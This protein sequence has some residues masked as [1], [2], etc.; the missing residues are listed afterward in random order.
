MQIS[1]MNK[2][3]LLPETQRRSLV[4][5]GTNAYVSA[6]RKIGREELLA[7]IDGKLHVDE[8]QTLRIRV[9]QTEGRLLAQIE[10][11]ARILMRV[12][13]DRAVQLEVDAPDSL[14]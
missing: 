14:A 9:P 5:G 11:R 8:I 4:N 10:A 3:D 7:V 13:R 12:Y 1:V 6:A 2:I